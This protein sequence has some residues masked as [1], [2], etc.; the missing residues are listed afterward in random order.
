MVVLVAWVA[1]TA[2]GVIGWAIG[3]KAGRAVDDRAGTAA[4]RCGIGAVQRGEEIFDR[5]P[6][7]AILMTPSWVAG[8]HRVRSRRLSRR[9]T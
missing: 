2:G 3:L 7:I 8:I 4:P 5:Y 9:P 1:A 6:V